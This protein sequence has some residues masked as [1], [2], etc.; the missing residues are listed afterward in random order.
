METTDHTTQPDRGVTDGQKKNE[1]MVPVFPHGLA[2]Y[3][4]G[5]HT[6]VEKGNHSQS[7]Q[8]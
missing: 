7:N 6:K 4:Y 8:Q 5:K 2:L 3:E 1:A